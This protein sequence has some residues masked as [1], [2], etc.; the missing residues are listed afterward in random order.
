MRLDLA[1]PVVAALEVVIGV[2]TPDRNPAVIVADG[3][4]AVVHPLVACVV[5]PDAQRCCES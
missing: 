5:I 2:Q 3:W 1:S 4:L